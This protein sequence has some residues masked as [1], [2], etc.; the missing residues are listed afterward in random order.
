MRKLAPLVLISFPLALT[1]P[2][3]A[4]LTTHLPLGSENAFTVPL[5]NL[6][7]LGWN[8]DRLFQGWQGYWQA[9][10]FH[11][12]S[13]AFAFSDP[14]PLTG[15]LAALLWPLSPAL[16]YNTILLLY[17]SLNGI[18]AYALLRERG[19]K[20]AAALAAGLTVQALP[21]LT[22]ERGVLQLQ[23]LF[24]PILAI[25]AL[26]RLFD[27]PTLRRA[28][29]LG[30]ATG[31]TFLT[32]EYYAL[33]LLPVIAAHAAF[34]PRA[35]LRRR[36]WLSAGLALAIALALI[37]P[38]AI[39]QGRY[40]QAMGFRRSATSLQHTSAQPIDYLRASPRLR[41]HSLLADPGGGSG[42]RLYPGAG[43]LTMGLAGAALG[44]RQDRRR[45][46]ALALIASGLAAGVLALGTNIQLGS[47]NPLEAM[48]QYI[49][50]L[51]WIR[52]PFRMTVYL[53]LSLA[54]L[55][56]EVFQRFRATRRELVALGLAVAVLGEI[57]PL[58]EPLRA[59]PQMN[60]AWA[61]AVAGR[62]ARVVAHVPWSEGESVSAYQQTSIWML[63]TLA[64]D[65]RLVNGYSGFF[66]KT[67]GQLRHLLE[68]FP[69]AAGLRALKV[70]GVEAVVIH[71]ELTDRE[72][73][74]LK[75][76]IEW[77]EIEVILRGR[78]LW[79]LRLLRRRSGS[80]ERYQGPWNLQA[81]YE[82]GRLDIQALA[83]VPD[84]S[85]YLY[86]V[87]STPLPL[88]LVVE[89]E[90]RRWRRAFRPAGTALLYHGSSV[91]LR[92]TWDLPL[93]AG[94]FVVSLARSD[95]LRPVASTTVEVDAP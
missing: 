38:V 60:P 47:L 73:S 3:A 75:E 17:M 7:T 33:L 89:G 74:F 87:W 6:W 5:L 13:G 15:P 34:H 77:G 54:L 4:H 67:N 68:R 21:F 80:A 43:L 78:G 69:S 82:R 35:I 63:Q 65:L 50:G 29:A 72:L 64:Q 18:S 31:V 95:D 24:G 51:L 79:G 84:A 14:Q 28:A 70:M 19:L 62:G 92:Q 39:P 40:L 46:W 11:P 86:D 12:T 26:W 49:P 83:T 66:P 53:Q 59:I 42:Q 90:T 16:A 71:R 85:I 93:P 56:G 94:S 48:R 44:L 61:R 27:G 36:L 41:V 8:A 58:P 37:L 1:W 2:L 91:R 81:E 25:S 22:H 23:A 88:E 55:A 32:S 10:I 9:P 76:A 57:W 20:P 45:R 30:L 52:S